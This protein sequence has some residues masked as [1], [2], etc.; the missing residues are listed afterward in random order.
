[1]TDDFFIRAILAGLGVALVSGPLGCF[2]VWRRMAYFGAALSHSALLGVAFGVA[3]GLSPTVGITAVCLCV[4]LLIAALERHKRLPSDTMMGIVA[5]G[6]LAFGLLAIGLMDSL[7]ADLISF[8]LGDILAVSVTD[9]VLIYGTVLVVGLVLLVIWQP[10]LSAAVHESL[11]A[12]E[13]TRVNLVRFVFMLLIALVVG[14][15]MKVIGLLLIVS[16]FLIPAAAARRFSDTPEQMALGATAIALVSVVLGLLA[17]LYLD[18]PSGPSI[19]GT[20]T[21]FFAMTLAWPNRR[22]TRAT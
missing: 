13:G 14:I 20:V 17:S 19:V 6:A 7:R 18:T 9:L 16:L 12:V 22:R 10:L 1:M 5:H 8:L 15:G 3:L 2:I 4:A 11:A 21:I